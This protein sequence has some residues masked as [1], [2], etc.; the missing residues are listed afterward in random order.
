MIKN[1]KPIAFIFMAM[2]LVFSSCKKEKYSFGDIK[3]P[4]NL[5]LT[6]AI[7]GANTAN[8]TGNGTG[9][10]T[11]AVTATNAITYKIDF[12]DGN[13][14]VVSSGTVIYKYTNPGT[15][16]YIVTINA[17][18]TGGAVSSIS[19]K[20]SV[21]VL[22]EIPTAMLAS[23]TGSSSKVW[24]TDKAAPGHFGVGAADMFTPN[25]Y[26]ATPNSREACAYDDEITFTRDANKNVSLTIDSKGES[27]SIGAATGNYGFGG[28]DGCY[29]VNTGG[30]RKL[31]F[32]DATSAS[33]P[34]VSTRIQFAVPTNGIIN[35]GTGGKVYEILSITNTQLQLR[36]IGAD[37][38][39]WYQMLKAK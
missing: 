15:F 34:A 22:F 11:I 25:Y 8:P 16:D 39:S 27:F 18:G 20:I 9:S 29:A 21:F 12:G 35:F 30:T 24:I 23:L 1:I 13:S 31:A 14:K 36:N 4:T 28:G 32:S 38:N 3:T 33:T 5:A 10:V 2:L 7:A 17:I 19:K 6:T 26:A 37:G